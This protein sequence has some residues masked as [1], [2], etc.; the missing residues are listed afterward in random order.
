MTE[1]SIYENGAVSLIPSSWEE[2]TPEQVRNVFK[3]YD[4]CLRGNASTLEFNV[5]VLYMLLG[6]KFSRRAARRRGRNPF[7]AERFGE[8]VYKICD[9]CLG[10]LFNKE[11]TGDG[12]KLAYA[13]VVNSLPVVRGV[14]FGSPLIGPA[15]LLQ[16][17]SFGEFRHAASA[18]NT[19]FKSN[20]VA[21]LDECI[22]HLYRKRSHRPNRCGRYV[23]D[24]EN[25]TFDKDVKRVSRLMGWQKNLIMAWFA[26]CLNYL[27]SES[28]VID[29]ETVNMA[30]MFAPDDDAK[31]SDI[32]FTWNDM[33]IQIAR[34]QTIGN[35]ERVDAEP[36]FSIFS[37]MWTNYKENK[38]NEDRTKSKTGK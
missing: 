26:S 36:L 30:L 23:K 17:L 32:T 27:Q 28:L 5:R 4:D 24:V 31:K 2:M 1:L 35:I 21:D 22:A 8:N 13:S 6:L 9:E 19:F 7:R 25:A 16:D 29:G 20:D 33:L 18:L 15:D 3:I 11:D 12:A 37:L 38:R 34:D 14:I 10:F